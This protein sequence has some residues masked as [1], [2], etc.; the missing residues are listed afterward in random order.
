MADNPVVSGQN[1]VDTQSKTAIGDVDGD[2][3]PDV[4]AT[5]KWN[6][7]IRVIATTDDQ[8]DGS[9][10]GDIKADFKTP[11]AKIFPS[12]NYFFEQEVG[13]ADIDKDGLGEMWSIVSKR[14]N[15]NDT[16]EEFY[17]VGFTYDLGP[18]KPSLEPLFDAVL[19]QDAIGDSERPGIFGIADFDG[20]MLVEIYLKD[21]IYA[22]ESG[23]LLA[24]G[25]AGDW[26][27]VVNSAPVAVDIIPGGNL[28]LVS[29][30]LIY[31]VPNLN[32]GSTA[33]LT[34][35]D[36]MNALAGDD[37]FPKLVNDLV[38]YGEDNFSSTSVADFDDD[39][40]LD[41]FL[42]G[43]L[44]SETGKTAVFYW[45]VS[46]PPD[47]GGRTSQRRSRPASRSFPAV[48]PSSPSRAEA[49]S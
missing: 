35:A 19:L 10:A 20:D 23:E 25:M 16:P 44:N 42:A 43:A 8:A 4:V 15:A 21:K 30:N 27:E 31:T 2:G 5:S 33:T 12:G 1:T 48:R 32:R 47:P 26:D 29:G 14:K 3:I 40:N 39:G 6:Q 24:D 17:L 45:D 37:W 34:V 36:D 13:I 38:E 28:E 7:T 18:P 11:G 41:V 49:I 46:S 9:D 22:A